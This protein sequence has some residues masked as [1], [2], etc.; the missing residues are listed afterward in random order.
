MALDILTAAYW[1]TCAVLHTK[2]CIYIS[3]YQHNISQA[4]A[5]VSQEIQEV[6]RLTGDSLQE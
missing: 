6:Q 5:G 3:N 2:C 4:L 1:D